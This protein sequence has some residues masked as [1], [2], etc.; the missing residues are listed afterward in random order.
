MEGIRGPE[1]AGESAMKI[2]RAWVAQ[3]LQGNL[4]AMLSPSVCVR[5]LS[6]LNHPSSDYAAIADTLAGDPYISAKVLS[7]ANLSQGSERAPITSLKRS[8]A[9]LGLRH[10]HMLVMSVLLT[11][12][13]LRSAS[14]DRRLDLRRWVLAQG[15]AAA[16]LSQH[17]PD[18]VKSKTRSLETQTHLVSGLLRGIGPIILLAG[19]DETYERILGW[20]MQVMDLAEWE[21]RTLGVTHAQVAHW[22]ML[23]LKCPAEVT[24]CQPMLP[25]R[26]KIEDAGCT[27]LCQRAIDVLAAAIARVET[28]RAEAWLI[29]ALPRLGVDV[30]D[31]LEHDL[32][33]L[34][35]QTAALAKVFEIDIEPK[36]A[37]WSP[38]QLAADAGQ[39]ME[40]A[41]VQALAARSSI[42]DELQHEALQ[43]AAVQAVQRTVEFDPLT[44][45]LNR[46]GW[47]HRL[48]QLAAGDDRA[49]ALLLVDV[50]G[51]RLINE[52]Y[53]HAAGDRLL[54]RLART[55]QGLQPAPLVIG[56]I[57][58]DELV[59]LL[60]VEGL[61]D[62]QQVARTLS[63]AL[64]TP[65]SRDQVAATLGI[66]L[67]GTRLKKL[68]RQWEG[69][70]ERVQRLR[71]DA[72]VQGPGKVS[73][74]CGELEER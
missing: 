59:V 56:R 10:T 63:M 28:G 8:V 6:Q 43:A 46:R 58:A 60:A 25:G 67:L 38:E 70:L 72:K 19:L 68:N 7:L 16:W 36:D 49:V 37:T 66:G 17:N 20:P 40:G 48:G 14:G 34:R 41:L 1:P 33:E 32:V 24:T 23:E 44:G 52:R 27:A 18:C 31:F 11:A 61:E 2:D 15:P 45:V 62:V 74:D 54:V 29:D 13:L 65:A 3:Q 22:A 73:G 64:A 26:Q 50:D 71:D 57:G 4:R 69:C 55:I 12:S 21:Q 39:L 5:L 9:V 51:F 30:T 42:A 47:Q 53:G 35:T